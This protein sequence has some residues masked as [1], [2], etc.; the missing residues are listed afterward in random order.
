MES[1]STEPGRQVHH[2]VSETRRAGDRAEASVGS[3]RCV[4]TG[5]GPSV[6]VD[7]QCEAIS[8]DALL[9]PL[10]HTNSRRHCVLVIIVPPGQESKAMRPTA[11]Y[12]CRVRTRRSGLNVVPSHGSAGGPWGQQI[13]FKF[14]GIKYLPSKYF[15]LIAYASFTSFTGA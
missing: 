13:N 2:A 4:I 3:A 15:I 8:C 7:E 10:R 9:P 12:G 14:K 6:A 1:V 5:T 11:A